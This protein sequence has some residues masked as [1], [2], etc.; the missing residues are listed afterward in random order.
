MQKLRIAQFITFEF[1]SQNEKVY[2]EEKMLQ[3]KNYRK[4]K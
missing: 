2:F 1:H 4:M 3:K